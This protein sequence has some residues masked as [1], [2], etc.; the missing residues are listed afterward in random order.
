METPVLGSHFD[1]ALQ[2]YQKEIPTQV[3]SCN[4]CEIFKNTYLKNISERLLLFIQTIC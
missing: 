1:K 2:L 4:Y 3:V